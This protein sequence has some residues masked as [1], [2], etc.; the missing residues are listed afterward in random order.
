MK[1]LNLQRK[2]WW[3][4]KNSKGVNISLEDINNDKNLL[5]HAI[6]IDSMYMQPQLYST[7]RNKRICVALIPKQI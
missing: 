4:F 7:F 3:R 1:K 2:V 6:M 5:V